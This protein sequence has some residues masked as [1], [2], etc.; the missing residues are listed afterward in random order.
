[1]SSDN[2]LLL[3]STG[4]SGVSAWNLESGAAV[5]RFYVGGGHTGFARFV[6]DDA[7]VLYTSLEDGRIYRQPV[8]IDKVI[9]TTC[10]RLVRD[11]TPGEQQLYSLD[12]SP[13]CPKF[14]GP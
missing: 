12:D 5:R 7:F 3:V 6:E 9:E 8:S 13:T 4:G 2:R 14:A 10:T 1:L 11:L